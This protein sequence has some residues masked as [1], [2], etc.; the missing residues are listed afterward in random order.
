MS[1]IVGLS[2]LNKFR[3]ISGVANFMIVL[4]FVEKSVIFLVLYLLVTDSHFESFSVG[5]FAK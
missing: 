2:S 3:Y 1:S 4:V 5:M